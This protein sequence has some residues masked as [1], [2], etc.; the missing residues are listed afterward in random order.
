[1]LVIASEGDNVIPLA[2]I[3]GALGEGFR[4]FVNKDGVRELTETL[5][6]SGGAG[7]ATEKW[8]RAEAK[9]N[10]GGRKWG[11]GRGGE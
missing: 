3:K 10:G 2:G 8:V 11:N 4:R 1:M 5:E 9:G 6:A 7:G